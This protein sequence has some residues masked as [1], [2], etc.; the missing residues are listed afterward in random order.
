M[1][2]E[3]KKEIYIPVL[4][5]VVGELLLFFGH[6][7]LS[8]AAYVINLQAITLAL[9]LGNSTLPV[10]NALQSLLL[11]ILLRII[12]LSMPHFFTSALLWYPLVYGVMFIPIYSI[13][14]NQQISSEEI[15]ADF[16]RLHIYIPAAIL[17][18]AAVAL[19]EYSILHPQSLIENIKP[20]NIVLIT[21]TML[22]FVGAV[23]ELIFRSILQ[24]R[25]ENVIGLKYGLLV[26]AILFGVMHAGYGIAKEVL[27]AI[28]FGIVIGYIFQKTRSYP[29]ILIIHSVANVFLFG[30]L[31][32]L[33][34]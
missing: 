23:E 27:F 6:V 1:N 24:T 4:G 17:I 34:R 33:L 11:L 9:I 21:T 30:L 28:L 8:L 7:S 3:M 18:G 26:S 13:I 25:L 10:K 32:I 15:G 2:N 31:P 14:K 20:Q 22:V 5:I 19:P 12:N 29:F 16:R